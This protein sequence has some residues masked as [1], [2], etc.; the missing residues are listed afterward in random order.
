MPCL[1]GTPA[2]RVAAAINDQIKSAYVQRKHKCLLEDL[3]D[4]TERIAPPMSQGLSVLSVY[5][6]TIF[7]MFIH[8]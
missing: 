1:S 6:Y 8:N 7:Y 5:N 2:Q 3:I 4:K